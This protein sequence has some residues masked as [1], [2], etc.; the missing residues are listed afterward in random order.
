MSTLASGYLVETRGTPMNRLFSLLIV[1]TVV[2]VLA[3]QNAPGSQP[4]A[5]TGDPQAR[6]T[7][8][9]PNAE[10]PAAQPAPASLAGTARPAKPAE[11]AAPATPAEPAAPAAPATP[12]EAAPADQP[13][14]RQFDLT[15][16]AGLMVRVKLETTLGDIVLELDGQKAPVT[17]HNFVR[18]TEGGFY[19]GTIFHR[20]VQDFMIQ[21]GQHLPDM[22]QKRE[23]LHPPILN[24][25]KNG[26]RNE[27]GTVAMARRGG[28]A[29]SAT[30]QFFINV[31]DNRN[32]DQPRDGAGYAVFGKV[33]EGMDVVDKIRNVE[34][35]SHPRY[36]SATAVVPVEP[37]VIN[38]A[39][40]AGEYDSAKLAAAV[41]AA[42]RAAVEE[43]QRAAQEEKLAD[44]ER[45]KAVEEAIKRIEEG[46]GQKMERTPSGLMYVML[47]EGD[48]PSPKPTDKVQV[49][50]VGWLLDNTV[51]DSSVSRGAP[52]EFAL[53]KVIRGWTEGVGLMKVGGKAKFLIPYE[54][55]YGERGM[56]P[57]IPPKSPLIFEIELLEIVNDKPATP[58]AAAPDP[59]LAAALRRLKEE[60]GRPMEITSSGLMYVML[61]EG[62]GPSPAPT[63]KVKVH[64]TGWLLDGTKFD[65]SVDRGAPTEFPLNQVIRGWTE[66][67]GLMKVG[68]KAKFL[69]PHELAYGERGR[70]PTIPPKAALIFEVELLDIVGR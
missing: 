14:E 20:I 63:D 69:I 35:H 1:L 28:Q 18:Y 7:Q 27:R 9:V 52:V 61:T 60:T 68:G 66:G 2:P 19:T 51:F 3:A 54:L 23:G 62:T 25:W 47:K 43:Q 32:L 59:A 31:V 15:D 57:R 38:K 65:S 48:G 64:Y 49:H 46:T 70:P 4:P 8:N 58:A 37:V 12:T 24:E 16:P 67:V 53:D 29:D 5:A 22:S 44:A 55:A 39:A 26:L 40:V 13:K 56:P 36:V 6:P 50:Y 45:Q 30:A 33:V 21:G 34:V 41:A 17:T 11:P 42:Q 10:A